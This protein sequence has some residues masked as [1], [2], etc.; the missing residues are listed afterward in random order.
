[1]V[2]KHKI[3][4]SVFLLAA[5]GT[6]VF[7]LQ[8]P[9]LKGQLTELFPEE[10]CEDIAAKAQPLIDRQEEDQSLKGDLQTA[11]KILA[12]HPECSGLTFNKLGMIAKVL[13]T[14]ESSHIY[15][16]RLPR[17]IR[18]DQH[19]YSPD[20]LILLTLEDKNG[21]KTTLPNGW[22]IDILSIYNNSSYL[23]ASSIK[24]NAAINIILNHELDY[25]LPA[26]AKRK[27]YLVIVLDQK[28]KKVTQTNFSLK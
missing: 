3:L 13:S 17:T 27:P 6:V 9:F 22:S 11:H 2:L 12:R 10:T 19:K 8:T 21:D 7:S 15:T 26:P 4:L 23:A 28:G 25:Q 14:K 1:M 20:E 24:D 16:A 5:A 18:I